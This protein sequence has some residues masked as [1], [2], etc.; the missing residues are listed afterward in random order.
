[1]MSATNVIFML[2]IPLG[3]LGIIGLVLLSGS[4]SP[5]RRRRLELA[6]MG[7]FYPGMTIFFA[8]RAAQMVMQ[9][10]W[11]LAALAGALSIAIAAQGVVMVRK[12]IRAD[13]TRT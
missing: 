6:M 1:M 5:H 11:L 7:V 2:A 12:H 4:L 8:V 3:L 13:G 10:E 9:A